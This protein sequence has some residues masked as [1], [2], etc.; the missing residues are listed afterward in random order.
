MITAKIAATFSAI[1]ALSVL[2]EKT[3]PRVA[4]ILTG[5]PLG[6][7]IVL[8]FY[9]L[10]SGVGFAAR[11][12]PY[13]LLGYIPSQSFALLYYLSS[14]RKGRSLLISSAAALTGYLATAWLFSRLDLSL[15]A[16][17]A[18]AILSIFLF[19][20]LFRKIPDRK[21]KERVPYTLPLLSMRAGLSAGIVLLITGVSQAVGPRWAGL[22]SAFPLVLYPLILLI[23][24]TYG[25]ET[26]HAVIKH[27]P[28][29]LLTVV[30]Y[31]ICVYYTYPAMGIYRGTLVSYAAATAFL[32]AFNWKSFFGS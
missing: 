30:V 26:V 28:R 19:S 27:F 16:S 29:G 6:T 7:A 4:G 17:A 15:A 25:A 1:L 14:R 32:L 5:Y 11:S 2:A 9:G 23:H 18:A 24:L 3:S 21:I 22:F 12:V 10:Q 8:F 13:N 31:S 20:L